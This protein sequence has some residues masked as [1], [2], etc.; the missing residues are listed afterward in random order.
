MQRRECALLE[1]LKCGGQS[2]NSLTVVPPAA[3]RRCAVV[4][5]AVCV[6]P[7]QCKECQGEEVCLGTDTMTS[8]MSR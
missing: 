7:S 2:P 1:D 6:R 8:A 3:R 5:L 4:L